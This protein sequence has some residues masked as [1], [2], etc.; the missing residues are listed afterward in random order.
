LVVAGYSGTDLVLVRYELD[1]TLDSTFGGGTGKVTTPVGG[2]GRANA[3]VQQAGDAKLVV[4]GTT[5]ADVVLARY[6]TTGM[7]DATF[8]G[9]VVT[10]TVGSGMSEARGLIQQA[11]DGKLVVAGVSDNGA[12][13]DF[14]LLR[15]GLDG[16]PDGTFG[17]AGVVT[18][19]VG[20]GND[21][22]FGL[23]EQAD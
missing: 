3:L 15:Y 16:M 22:A 6:D 21:A 8:G 10:K 20:T 18:T 5:G 14:M 1:G 11:G 4:A 9:G 23:A 17:S 7:L 12:N 13:T 19:A 2:I